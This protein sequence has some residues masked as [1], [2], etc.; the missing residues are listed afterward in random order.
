MTDSI[1]IHDYF[2][3]D[4]VR[5]IE[6]F[7]NSGVA[8]LDSSIFPASTYLTPQQ[9]IVFRDAL[10]QRP[11]NLFLEAPHKAGMTV[12]TVELSEIRGWLITVGSF[13]ETHML[14]TT[15]PEEL[16]DWL[17]FF[18]KNMAHYNWVRK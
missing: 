17:Q 10:F 4:S 14:L 12:H 2:P 15:I 11:S 8:F 3:Q 1:R 18:L 13:E 9:L 5:E 7:A 6:A 16:V